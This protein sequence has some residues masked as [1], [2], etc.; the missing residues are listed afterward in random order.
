[1]P[2]AKLVPRI[3]P[4]RMVM[5]VLPPFSRIAVPFGVAAVEEMV[6]P[7]KSSVTPST[8]MSMPSP[9]LTVMLAVR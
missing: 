9:V 2:L 1:M 7:F 8:L 4:L 3:W 6:N 5:S